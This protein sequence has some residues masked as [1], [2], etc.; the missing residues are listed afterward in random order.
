MAVSYMSLERLGN[1]IVDTN[2]ALVFDTIIASEGLSSQFDYNT[3]T[4]VITFLE[5]GYYFIDWYVAPQFGFT[6]D[7]SNWAIQT[8]VSGLTFT[9][10]SHTKVSVTIGFALINA[11]VG[12]TV[13]LLNASDGALTLS[14]AVN[15]KAGLIIYCV[16][17]SNFSP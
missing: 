9:G 5:E 1:A 11:E 15:S 8:S 13:Q 7:G 3:N 6:T 12:E 17:T 16:S 10:S 4:G 14:E 2:E